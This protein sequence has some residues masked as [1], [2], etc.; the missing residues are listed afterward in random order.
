MTQL[1]MDHGVSRCFGTTLAPEAVGLL[2]K[3]LRAKWSETV[4]FFYLRCSEKRV[5]AQLVCDCVLNIGPALF[6]AR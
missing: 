1:I 3:K 6:L 2:K 4:S 5:P